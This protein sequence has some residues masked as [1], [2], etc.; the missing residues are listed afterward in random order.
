M[1]QARLPDVNTAF[2]KWRNKVVT[3]L[4]SFKYTAALGS[5]NNFNACLPR[6]YQVKVSTDLYNQ[7]LE[8][9]KLLVHCTKCGADVDFR[10]VRKELVLCDPMEEMIT[11]KKHKSVWRCSACNTQNLT[12]TSEFTK[13]NLPNPYY[14]GVVPDPPERKDGILDRHEYHR[15]IE[16]WC[17]IMLGELEFMAA[18]FRDDSWQKAIEAGYDVLSGDEDQ[19]T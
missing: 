10:H 18:K 13:A 12:N 5:L 8:D 2:I 16:R 19:D 14:I 1:P 4:E 3:A 9:E 11:K 15:K 7:K 6:E 17:W